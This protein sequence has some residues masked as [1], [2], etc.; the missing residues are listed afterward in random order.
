MTNED[1]LLDQSNQ[2]EKNR[3]PCNSAPPSIG[4]LRKK[5]EELLQAQRVSSP[6]EL[7]DI[8]IEEIRAKLH[9]LQI[10]QI[11]LEM[12]NEELR[13]AH[14]E[15]YA[16]KAHYFKFY[17]LAPVGYCT[18]NAAGLIIEINLTLA[19]LLG[20]DRNALLQHPISSYIFPED[21]DTFYL[22]C[23]QLLKTRQPQVCELRITGKNGEVFW[24]RLD[25]N[26]IQEEN[27]SYITRVVLTNI[28]ERKNLE[29]EKQ[30]IEAQYRQ[31]Q[32]MESVGRLAG[33]VAHDFNNKLT[34]ILGF[35]D[36]I[37]A[38]LEPSKP[39]Y[40]DLEEIRQAAL[41][42]ADLTR[43]LLAFSRKQHVLPQVIDLN[44]TVAGMLKML[45]RLIGG[46]ITLDWL[47]K[48]GL[49]SVKMDPSQVDQI[50]AN[51]CV[52][53]RDAIV[54]VGQLTI[55]TD[56]LVI[57]E[58]Y[59]AYHP[60]C[61]PGE[62]VVLTVTDN[63]CGMDKKTMNMIFE[64]FF[65]TKEPG[66]G[67]GLGL[68]SVYGAVK[69]NNGF[70]DVAS[71]PGIGTTFKI[72]L[73]R[74]KDNTT[75]NPPK[76]TFTPNQGKSATILLV[77]DEEA[78]LNMVT[79]HLEAFGYSVLAANTPMEAL[80]LAEGYPGKI[81]LLMTDLVMPQMT[82]WDLAK[83]LLSSYPLQKSL[84]M[85]G[86]TFNSIA[87]Q[88]FVVLKEQFLQKPFSKNQL[89]DKILEALKGTEN[90]TR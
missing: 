64:P 49:W 69:Q 74:Q 36:L 28:S 87:Q 68:S 40:A 39:I 59:C 15:T 81:D 30:I 34:I 57:D 88:G 4:I 77:D 67:T 70:I 60:N 79:R 20:L 76:S 78:L 50:L 2:S 12:Q 8:S 63:G 75:L 18:L 23:K 31:A 11:E 27:G 35:A 62:Y 26:V 5:A 42:S 72:Y 66:I 73:P 33:G 37:M 9:E 48:D 65:T 17:D 38:E 46:N 61:L 80:R 84:F 6:K 54:G 19:N 89:A 71:E 25:S 52:N 32:K 58:S 83:K 51:L 7:E 29:Q 47:P 55:A 1:Q 14:E 56:N 24:T 22:H 86:H 43:Q 3:L 13:R 82:G 21:Q 53:A 16:A 41:H 45:L 85:S 10:Y 44:S 90:S